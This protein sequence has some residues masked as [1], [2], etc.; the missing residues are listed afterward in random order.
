MIS[1]RHCRYVTWHHRCA[2]QQ[3]LL[4]LDEARVEF[5]WNGTTY[6][7]IWV[8][9]PLLHNSNI[10]N[11]SPLDCQTCNY[12]IST[13]LP[14]PIL[15]PMSC[16]N[17][18]LSAHPCNMIPIFSVYQKFPEKFCVCIGQSGSTRLTK[19]GFPTE[20]LIHT[21][22]FFQ[23]QGCWII[24]TAFVLCISVVLNR[25]L[26]NQDRHCLWKQCRS[27]SDDFCF[28][29]NLWIDISNNIELSHWLTEMGVANLIYSAGQWLKL[30]TDC[31][32]PRTFHQ[33][34]KNSW[35]C[36]KT[37]GVQTQRIITIIKWNHY[38]H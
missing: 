30:F 36:K 4:Q 31:I 22:F 8:A 27:R 3:E 21:M 19:Q 9:K 33:E 20:T 24:W 10:C 23:A 26:L 14:F 13:A 18:Y 29:F 7:N 38:N 12:H 32:S 34:L 5:L 28:S 11:G 15:V 16:V 6:N 25:V 17:E 35:Q 37:I 1:W 2:T